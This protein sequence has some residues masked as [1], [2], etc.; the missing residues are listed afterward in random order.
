M[1]AA[2]AFAAAELAVVRRNRLALAATVMMT[3]FAAALTLLGAGATGALGVDLLTAAIASLST[4]S[5]Y[6]VPLIALLLAFDAVA[7]EIERGALALTLSYPAP[8]LALL[9]GKLIAHLAALAAAL[10]A[11]FGAA[12]VIA[13][14]RGGASA[15][16]LLALARLGATALLLGAA[17]LGIGY[18][19]SARAR[20]PGAAAGYAIGAWLVFVV[21]YDIALLGALV[22]SDAESLFTRQV[23]PWLLVANPA[24]AF[25]LLNLPPGEAVA[26]ASGFAAAGASAGLA[27]FVSLA[28]WPLAA[29]GLAWASFRRIEP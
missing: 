2:L 18:A 20:S 9:A 7:G 14:A 29:L 26:L 15:D 3:L 4:L 22:A 25:R 11:G 1:R 12:A 6:L 27:P 5:V 17:F 24:D 23:F 19:L 10:A 8:R 16:S 28:L 13:L 21:L